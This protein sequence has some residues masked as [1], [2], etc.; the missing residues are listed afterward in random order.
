VD[1]IRNIHLGNI[2]PAVM[3][4]QLKHSRRGS[5]EI[6]FCMNLVKIYSINHDMASIII[7]DEPNAVMPCMVLTSH[8]HGVNTFTH[9]HGISI[10]TIEGFKP[11]FCESD[12][13]DEVH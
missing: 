6:T 2:F 12:C 7:G 11:K 8:L 1:R 5:C 4:L 3:M 10:C 9:C 13:R